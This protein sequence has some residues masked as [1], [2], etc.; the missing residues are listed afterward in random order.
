MTPKE[1]MNLTQTIA[2]KFLAGQTQCRIKK[3]KPFADKQV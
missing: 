2:L 3:K 1:D